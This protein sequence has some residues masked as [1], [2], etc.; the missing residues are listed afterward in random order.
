MHFPHF[1][2]VKPLQVL[3]RRH[4]M[5]TT[6]TA[7]YADGGEEK[8]SVGDTTGVAVRWKVANFLLLKTLGA[9]RSR[10]RSSRSTIRTPFSSISSHPSEHIVG[11]G[12]G[13][14]I[15]SRRAPRIEP[16]DPHRAR[17]SWSH[18]KQISTG[19]AP[20]GQGL[21]EVSSRQWGSSAHALRCELYTSLPTPVAA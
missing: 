16:H 11:Q 21:D 8:S 2:D 17:G 6:I 14:W 7:P 19:M 3:R 10:R 13:T 15:G 5:L 4:P 20:V 1:E 9:K 18:D 12:S